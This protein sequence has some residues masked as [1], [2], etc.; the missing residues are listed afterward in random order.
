MAS[1]IH[2]ILSVALATF[3]LCLSACSKGPY[4]M[5][6]TSMAPTLTNG[7]AFKLHPLLTV[8][9]WSVVLYEPPVMEGPNVGWAGRIVGLPGESLSISNG[10]LII[11]GTV[12]QPP[13][14]LRDLR[15][16]SQST[17]PNPAVQ[18][19][20]QVKPNSVFILGDNASSAYDSRY[21]GSIDESR[22]IGRIIA[23]LK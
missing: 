23:D 13:R 1:T 16:T 12:I 15:F 19:P 3:L 2:L 20:I 17:N 14:Q 22:L 10:R 9:R 5:R 4:R 21:F 6:D 11:D 8:Q 18:Y 7:Q